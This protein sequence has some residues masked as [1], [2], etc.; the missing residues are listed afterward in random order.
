MKQLPMTLKEATQHSIRL[1]KPL[2]CKDEAVSVARWV[3]SWVTGMSAAELI[4]HSQ[5][6]LT[7][8]QMALL[9]SSLNAHITEHKPLQ[10]I[11]GSVPFLGLDI[12]VRPPVLIPRPETEFWCSWLIK[13]LQEMSPRPLT[14][15]DMCTGSGCIALSLA[16]SLPYASVYAADISQ[17]ACALL[18]V[19]MLVQ[20]KQTSPSFDQI[21]SPM[22]RRILSSISL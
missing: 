12:H 2:Y 6:Q 13:Q 7:T 15:L 18:Q 14:I 20:I 10:Y 8:A 3:I 22:Y 16:H 19:K 5:Q 17:E 4:S 1:L 9:T 21:F 11:F